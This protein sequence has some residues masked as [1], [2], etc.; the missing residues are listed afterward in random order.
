M[1]SYDLIGSAYQ[2]GV[3]VMVFGESERI[4][5]G[6]GVRGDGEIVGSA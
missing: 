4:V 2:S 3:K 1:V 5:A 6:P